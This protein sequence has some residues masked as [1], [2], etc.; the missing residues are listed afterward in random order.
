MNNTAYLQHIISDMKYKGSQFEYKEERDADLLRA[1]H[2]IIS[3]MGNISM[4]EVAAK[5][6]ATPSKRFWVSEE[7]ADIIVSRLLKGKSISNMTPTKQAMFHEIYH[8]YLDMKKANPS[9][10]K[11]D[12]IFKVCNEQAPRFYLTTKSI[13]VLL[14]KARKEEKERCYERRKKRL[15][16]MF[17][18]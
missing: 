7:R 10:A 3:V 16:F 1:Y 13:L 6:A 11:K 15:R 14:H 18:I 5:I 9:L 2:E 4:P 8:R 12:I 17:G